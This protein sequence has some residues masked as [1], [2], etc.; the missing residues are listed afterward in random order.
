MNL[1]ELRAEVLAHGFDQ[2]QYTGRVNRYLNDALRLLAR[3][4]AFYADE[5]ETPIATA[6][7]QV[8]YS[9]PTDFGKGRSLRDADSGAPLRLLGLRE[10]DGAPS[11]AGRPFAYAIN[12]A[13]IAL[14]PAPDAAYNLALRYWRLPPALAADLDVP[15]IPAD[16]HGALTYYA[17][18]RCYESEDDT[19][20]GGYW[21]GQWQQ[22]LRDMAVDVK[23]PTTD[24]PRVVQSMWDDSAAGWSNNVLEG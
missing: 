6:A 15:A 7:G 11:A 8:L 20:M 13:A 23:F 19:Q 10:L 5:A 1:Y 9:W 22:A 2:A 16:Y 21:Q 17:L 4:I 12:G 18:Q 3:K 24:G 14:W